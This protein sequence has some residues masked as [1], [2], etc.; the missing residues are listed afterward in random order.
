MAV[1]IAGIAGLAAGA[2][3]L[4]RRMHGGMNTQAAKTTAVRVRLAADLVITVSR[5]LSW[6]ASLFSGDA[7]GSLKAPTASSPA[8]S[9]WAE[10]R[11][12]VRAA[13]RDPED[14]AD[15]DDDDVAEVEPIEA[16]A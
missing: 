5:T 1:I 8:H 14:I 3:A 15:D 12:G 7:F 11:F 4:W 16:A 6:V 2:I 13:D 9:R 10:R